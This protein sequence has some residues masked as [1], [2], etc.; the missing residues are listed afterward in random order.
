[1]TTLSGS[2]QFAGVG[3]HIQVGTG[4]AACVFMQDG[5]GLPP[6][7]NLQHMELRMWMEESKSH[8]VL[9]PDE[10]RGYC[11]EDTIP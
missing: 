9:P 3:S 5:S 11:E 10:S 4:V 8:F 1:M 6:N 7:S 2:L